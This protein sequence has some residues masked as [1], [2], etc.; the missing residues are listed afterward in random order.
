MAVRKHSP[1]Q[2]RRVGGHYVVLSSEACASIVASA[3]H[4]ALGMWVYLVDKPIDWTIRKADIQTRF[5][6][7]SRRAYE[8]A[9][10]TLKEVG[11]LKRVPIFAENGRLAGSELVVSSSFISDIPNIPL[12]VPSVKSQPLNI[13]PTEHTASRQVGE[14]YDLT[15]SELVPKTEITK[16]EVKRTKKT[17]G[18]SL[19]IWFPRDKWQAYCE[20]RRHKKH[21]MTSEALELLV[22]AVRKTHNAG[23]DLDLII[24]ELV[25]TGWRTAK[26]EYFENKHHA[27]NNRT[28]QSI[29]SRVAAATGL[30]PDDPAS[31]DFEQFGNEHD[32]RDGEADGS[33]VVAVDGVTVRE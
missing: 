2:I 22:E 21:P 27:K 5:P 26:P 33:Q 25:A 15:K 18:F 32:R 29:V 20:A 16:T 6:K 28:G 19:P 10:R 3:D 30:D 8:A 24:D 13:P 14:R 4:V 23:I 1:E 7:I 17:S 31:Y 9:I 12:A 11:V